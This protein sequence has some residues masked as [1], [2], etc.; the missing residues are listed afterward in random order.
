MQF[1]LMLFNLRIPQTN[2]D[3]SKACF[4]D[5]I[6]IQVQKFVFFAKVPISVLAKD[7]ALKCYIST[8]FI[9][10]VHRDN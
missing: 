5:Q 2:N 1:R 6:A 8:T 10:V 4:I 7:L 9:D 3:S